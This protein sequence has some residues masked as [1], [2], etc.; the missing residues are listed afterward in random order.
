MTTRTAI[1]LATPIALMAMLTEGV[2]QTQRP[3]RVFVAQA[4]TQS[5]PA[6][7]KGDD[8]GAPAAPDEDGINPLERGGAADMSPSG[9]SRLNVLESQRYDKLIESCPAFVLLACMRI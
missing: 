8:R 7:K 9:S 1:V 5:Q 2:P 4:V 6:R 3:E